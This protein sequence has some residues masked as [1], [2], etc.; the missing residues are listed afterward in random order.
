MAWVRIDDHFDEHPKLARVGPL[1]WAVWM[2]GLAYANRN[3]TDGFIPWSVARRLVSWDFLAPAQA[4]AQAGAQAENQQVM[5]V[6]VTSGMAG[7][8][9]TNE[10]VI[11]LLIEAGVWEECRGG[12]CIHDY[13]EYQRTRAEI[14]EE[15]EKKRRAGQAGGQARAQ[16]SA[17]ARAQADDIAPAQA[18]SKQNSSP[19]PNPYKSPNGLLREHDSEPSKPA[20]PRVP[21]PIFDTFCDVLGIEP[22]RL[23]KTERGRLNIACKDVRDVQGTPDDIRLAAERY[24][25]RWPDIDMT[26]KGIAG[27]WQM[28]LKDTGISRAPTAEEV[29]GNIDDNIRK[30]NS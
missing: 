3:M 20:R 19:N 15:R 25:Q 26:A 4:G 23:N 12:Y 29:Y 9:V 14:E 11:G 5:T 13:G 30:W 7:Q 21:D 17:K 22:N 27:N 2:A 18:E 8:D 6:S 10:Y 28:L 16:A 24:R 1:G